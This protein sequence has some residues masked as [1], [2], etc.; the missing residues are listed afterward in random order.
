MIYRDVQRRLGLDARSG[1]AFFFGA[2]AQT[3]FLWKEF[4]VVLEQ[5]ISNPE[6]AAS[7][8]CAMF[9]AFREGLHENEE[10]FSATHPASVALY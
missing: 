4:T 5:Q 7:A 8:A 3:G 9:E 6:L 10:A 1:A 2:G